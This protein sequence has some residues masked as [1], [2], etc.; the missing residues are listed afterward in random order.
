MVWAAVA[1]IL[2][3]L[4]SLVCFRLCFWQSDEEK[5]RIP[6]FPETDQ[7]TP[8]KEKMLALYKEVEN[9]E[10]EEITIKSYDKLTL[11]G[12]FY[13]GKE[14][15]PVDILFH[16][17]RSSAY[18]DFCAGC[19][20]SKERG[21]NIILVDQRAHGKSGGHILTFGIKE[22]LDALKWANYA[23]KRFGK[24][25]PIY[26]IGVSMGAATVLSASDLDLPSSVRGIIADCPFSTPGA[27]IRKVCR[28]M[29]IPSFI[30]YP[31]IFIGAVIFGHF[32]PIGGAK[33]SVKKTSLPILIIHGEADR[34]V[35]HSMSREI[36]EVA[37]GE[38]K[39]VSV[40]EAGHGVSYF[41]DSEGYKKAL[42]EF[43]EMKN[44]LD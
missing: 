11:Y 16:G 23:E 13:K 3:I 10:Y 25:T 38:K 17:Y 33:Y 19:K 36:Y 35:P 27:I 42:T 29:K 44:D 7:Y 6:D 28:D 12:R 32:F 24:E 4:I 1:L 20:L 39:L 15:A 37:A 18:R 41:V 34:F 21:H 31:F 43:Y 5:A 22:R 2:I 30:A 14:G 26:L 8:Y 40:P 9:A